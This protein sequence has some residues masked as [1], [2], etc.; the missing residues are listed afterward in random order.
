MLIIKQYRIMGILY[1]LEAGL[2]ITDLPDARLD[3]LHFGTFSCVVDVM[4][5]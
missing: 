5:V 1:D 3:S 2:A 4:D